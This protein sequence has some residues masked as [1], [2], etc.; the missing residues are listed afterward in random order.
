[1]N[2]SHKIKP[3]FLLL[4]CFSSAAV[5]AQKGTKFKVTLD[6]GHGGK[7]FGAVYNGHVEKNI[8]LSVAL[9]VGKILEGMSAFEVNYTRKTDVFIDLVE[10]ANIANRA[11]ANIF[12]SI[13]CNANP[14]TAAYGTETHVMGMSKNAS[15]LAVAKRENEVITMEKDYKE[16]YDGFDPNSPESIVN[17]TLMVEENLENSI[18][19]ASKI[20]KRF[21]NDL[22]KR[23]RG[24]KQAPYMVLH[25][26]F[27]PRVLI[28]MGFI[29]NPKEGGDLDTEEGQMEIAQAIANAI[30]SYKKDYF[31][32]GENE[33]EIKPSQR[34]EPVKS[35]A[36]E[37]KPTPGNAPV[38][39]DKPID[40][41]E[42]ANG[43]VIFKVQISASGKKLETTPSNFKGLK[44]I[45]VTSDNGTLYKYMYGETTDYNEAKQNLAEAKAKGFDSAY[46]IAFRDGRKITIQEALK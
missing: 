6:A 45:S 10:R 11:D 42:V 2:F 25:K 26:A 30:V 41:T 27:M 43:K 29:S 23:D 33:N 22:K 32:S 3:L 16:K 35:T 38:Q 17:T 28:E 4:L 15:A 39:V 12:V 21:T 18:A 14:N 8:A 13:H 31:G 24:V 44:N 9:K 34:I 1:M 5:F 46:L 40:K 20:Q 36:D 7:D 19:L 37:D